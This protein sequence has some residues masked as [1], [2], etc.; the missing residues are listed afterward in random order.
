MRR[1]LPTVFLA[2]ALALAGCATE[3]PFI[4]WNRPG[5]TPAQYNADD[6]A[7]R[8]YT[9]QYVTMSGASLWSRN[10]LG[11]QVNYDC[12]QAKGWVAG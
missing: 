9:S 6:A 4:T 1:F 8:L 5:G 3:H 11:W 7:C 12:M 2:A 10:D